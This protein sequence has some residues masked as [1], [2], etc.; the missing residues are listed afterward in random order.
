MPALGRLFITPA[1]INKRVTIRYWSDG[2][3]T[4]VLGTLVK[5]QNGKFTVFTKHEHEVSVPFLKIVA[6][7]VVAPEIGASWVEAMATKVWG[8]TETQLL[9]D[10]ILQAAGGGASRVNSCLMVGLPNQADP[11]LAIK[12]LINWY[13]VRNL[14]PL[15]QIS[16][17]GIYDEYLT[18]AGFEK[19][20]LIDFLTK[21]ITKAEVNMDFE[22]TPDLSDEW[23]RVVNQNNGEKRQVDPVTLNS[24][25]FVRFFS[26]KKADEILATARLAITDGFALVTNLWVSENLRNQGVAQQLMQ[27]VENLAIDAKID[28]IWLQ[29]LHS[30]QPA[31][32]LYKKIGYELHH[33]YC[34]WAYPGQTG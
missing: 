8:A 29:V 22:T 4:D 14:T 17:P 25:S 21:L 3:L 32:A 30:N 23:L 9:G 34:Y 33:Q 11:A 19:I 16:L 18:K 20:Y 31:Q 6:A 1:D 5:Y 24:G 15:A 28:Q 7:K 10:W 13:Q 2:A 12:E 26:F 27:C